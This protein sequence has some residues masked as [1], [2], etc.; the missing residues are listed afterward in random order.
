MA[1]ITSVKNLRNKLLLL[2]FSG[3]LAIGVGEIAVRLLGFKPIYATYSKSEQFWRRD[4]LLGW[5]HEPHAEGT[6]VG[7]RPFPVEFRS[8][9]R[10]NSLG[11]RG[12]E[13]APL[14]PH[15]VR[16]LALGDSQVAGFEVEE[17][18]TFIH[19]LEQSLSRSDRP[20]QVIN[21]GIRGYGTDQEYL[22]FKERLSSLGARVVFLIYSGND[23]EDNTTLHRARRPF[24]KAAFSI[25]PEGE[26]VKVGY[27]IPD[28]PFCSGYRLDDQLHIVR[29]DG[30]RSR[31]F[32]WTESNLSDHSALMTLVAMRIRQNPDLLHRVFSLSTPDQQATVND[33]SAFRLTTLLLRKLALEIRASGASLFIFASHAELD[34]FEPALKDIDDVRLLYRE[35]MGLRTVSDA[36]PYCFRNDSHFNVAGHRLLADFLTPIVDA[37]LAHG[38]SP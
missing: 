13:I 10:I 27:P 3:A 5:G 2:G 26:L 11:L 19:L 37:S 12:P 14:P 32:C 22:L 16:V 9:V 8:K 4:D 24:G 28:Y 25:S 33:G 30:V 17:D 1:R 18:Q 20:V 21:A 7:P 15:G 34:P 36:A 31:T 6:F 38:P 35:D 23:L 29:I